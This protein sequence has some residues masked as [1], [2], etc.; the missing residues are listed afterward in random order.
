MELGGNMVLSG[1]VLL[2]CVISV[3][4]VVFVIPNSWN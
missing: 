4:M 2:H 1:L 3:L